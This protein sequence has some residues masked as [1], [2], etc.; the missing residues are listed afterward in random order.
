[1]LDDIYREINRRGNK[2][3][4]QQ[5][6]RFFKTGESSYSKGDVFLGL[7]AKD[8]DFVSEK[9]VDLGIPFVVKLLKSEIHDYRD[10]ALSILVLKYKK[11]DKIVKDKVVKTYLANKKYVNNWDLVDG[12]AYKI[13]GDYLLDKSRDVLYKLACSKV[14]WDRR[15]AIVSTFAFI[16]SGDTKDAVKISKILLNNREDLMHKAVGWMLREVGKKDEKILKDFL[17]KNIK[18]MPRTTLRYSIERF[19]E[20]IRQYYLKLK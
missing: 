16:R 5:A 4:A 15:I 14:M 9:Y 7:N 20:N 8:V 10:V 1:M 11:G 2:I 12:S 3:K 17:N 6:Q 18:V 13:L 19:P